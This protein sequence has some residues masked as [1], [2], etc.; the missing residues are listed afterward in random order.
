MAQSVNGHAVGDAA[1]TGHGFSA[2][3]HQGS[4]Y[5]VCV[6]IPPSAQ[7]QRCSKSGGE[8]LLG[9][10]MVRPVHIPEA[11]MLHGP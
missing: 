7:R 10:R 4:C 3:L 8:A 6:V 9:S 1:A 5:V 11:C 2:A